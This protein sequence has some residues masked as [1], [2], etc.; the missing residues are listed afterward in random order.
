MLPR[1]MTK[2]V[3]HFAMYLL[4]KD[5]AIW[6]KIYNDKSNPRA[7]FRIVKSN[8]QTSQIGSKVRTKNL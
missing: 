2:A 4:F 5:L 3:K 1:F 7:M 6:V 8:A